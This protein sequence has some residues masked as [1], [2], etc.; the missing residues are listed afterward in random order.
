ETLKKHNLT[1]EAVLKEMAVVALQ[2][3]P[4]MLAIANTG[5]DDEADNAIR[6]SSQCFAWAFRS[7]DGAL[8]VYSETQ[9]FN[10]HRNTIREHSAEYALQRISHYHAKI[11]KSA[12]ED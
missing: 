5:V 7:N 10:G 8:H 12:F 3:R 4:D 1:S 9:R 2:Q 11:P 6:A